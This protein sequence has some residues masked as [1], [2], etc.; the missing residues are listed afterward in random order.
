MVAE[1]YSIMGEVLHE[2][3]REREA[4][5]AYDSCLVYQ[6]DNASCLN[7]YAYFL[8]LRSE[9]LDR[10]EE[11]SFRSLRLEP[12]N[13]TYL[14]TYA[15]ILFM[16]ERYAE[17]QAFID[18]VCPPDSADSVLLSDDALSGVVFEH[19]GDIAA[20]NGDI[21]HALRFWQLARQAGGEGL[22]AVLP[23]KIKLKKYIKP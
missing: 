22:T 19:A 18:R 5:A 7:N 23:K 21:E 13:K 15:W 4:F 16:K 20:C 6:S 10:A 11:M 14:D 8:S 2:M 12:N 17:A 1:M 3:G 9:N